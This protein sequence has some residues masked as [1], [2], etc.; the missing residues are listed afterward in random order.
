MKKFVILGTIMISML[1]IFTNCKKDDD[2]DKT[3]KEM[4]TAKSWK[5]K[6][7]TK[8]DGS[9]M[10]EDCEKDDKFTF[11]SG[12]VYTNDPSTV[13]CDNDDATKTGTW[14]LSADE[15]TFTIVEGNDTNALTV[16]SV[17]ENELVF[18]NTITEQ[19]VTIEMTITFTPY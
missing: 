1:L 18:K 11:S 14:T 7:I 17:K 9:S 8:A 4:I 3:K 19:G 13:K 2:D 16:V 12:G 5:Y 10:L 6:T 15:K